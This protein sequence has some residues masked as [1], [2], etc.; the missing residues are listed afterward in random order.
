MTYR[1][2]KVN[3]AM[4]AALVK[5]HNDERR[6]QISAEFHY[7]ISGSDVT[8]DVRDP[9][10]QDLQVAAAAAA[11]LATLLTLSNELLI[12]YTQH[13]ADAHV[14]DMADTSNEIAAPAATDL[15]TAQTLLNE[16][17]TDYNLHLAQASVHPNDDITNDITSAN[18]TNQATAETLAN[19]A[20]ADLNAHIVAALVGQGIELIAP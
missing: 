12:V 9:V 7:D 17:K 4:I 13:I 15:T 11:D 5:A 2:R 3:D 10:Q 6:A 19:E 14:H 20:K 16:I 18:A 1:V 8:G